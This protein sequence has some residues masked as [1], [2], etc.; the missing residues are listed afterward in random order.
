MTVGYCTSAY[1]NSPAIITT[2]VVYLAP[3]FAGCRP[4][5]PALSHSH[6][7]CAHISTIV[8]KAFLRV[9]PLVNSFR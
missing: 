5:R 1:S 3:G 9:L 2:L 4:A 7:S 6:L 8:T